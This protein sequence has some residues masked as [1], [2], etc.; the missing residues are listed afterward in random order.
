MS[1]SDSD[2]YWDGYDSDR[3]GEY[4][5]DEKSSRQKLTYVNFILNF[6]L[7]MFVDY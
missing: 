5:P 7:N 3:D 6:D 4:V 1:Y 2:K